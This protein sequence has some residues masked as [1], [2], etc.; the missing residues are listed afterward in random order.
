MNQKID[1]DGF[2]EI[3]VFVR[4]QMLG[5]EQR[6]EMAV[7]VELRKFA[8]LYRTKVAPADT[9]ISELELGDHQDH[10]HRR[11][12]RQSAI[13]LFGIALK[14]AENDQHRRQRNV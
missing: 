12:Q 8:N 1:L 9:A 13:L 10:Q 5:E 2:L 7:G 14:A 11:S 3:S 6:R 4:H